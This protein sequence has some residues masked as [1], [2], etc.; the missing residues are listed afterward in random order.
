VSQIYDRI[1]TTYAQYRR[2][3][4]R[5]AAQILRALGE[6]RS[7]VNI[8]AGTGSYEP[9]DRDV[10]AVEPSWTMI[11][12]RRP[13]AAPVVCA[14]AEALPFADD[15]FD[16]SLA[17]LTIHHWR[18]R[19]AGLSETARV[20]RG[21]SV[22]VTFDIDFPVDWLTRDYFPELAAA[23]RTIFPVFD[24]YR[25]FFRHVDA[26][27]LMVPHDCSDGFLEAYW[28]RPEAIFDPGMR[29]AIS[30]FDGVDTGPGLARLRRDLND[31]TWL[32]RNGHLLE[33]TEHDLGY[34]IVT[35]GR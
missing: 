1:G 14:V 30:A 15:S 11:R 19:N 6:A 7:V 16:A 29:S 9:P 25:R 22:F 24:D 20:T 27:P 12:Q 21:R 26:V 32:R 28:R 5:L 3:D 18:D 17:I 35:A 34:R 13:D 4:P 33:K 23:D 31:G 10:V 2:P 8:G